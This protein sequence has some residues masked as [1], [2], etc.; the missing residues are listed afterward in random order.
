MDVHRG[1]HGCSR[2]YSFLPFE[3][4]S[5]RDSLHWLYPGITARQWTVNVS[6]YAFV[7]YTWYLWWGFHLRALLV[8]Q[9]TVKGWGLST[10]TCLAPRQIETDLELK[11]RGAGMNGLVQARA[12]SVTPGVLIFRRSCVLKHIKFS[13][14]IMCAH[15]ITQQH[16]EDPI[17]ATFVHSP[18][19]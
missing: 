1:H 6:T 10:M 12:R 14:P 18:F 9:W 17:P 13:T 19:D 8:T 4:W 11:V 16:L 15:R 5:T 3:N 7:K 2:M